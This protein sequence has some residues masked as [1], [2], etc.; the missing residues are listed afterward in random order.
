MRGTEPMSALIDAR[1]RSVF[2]SA[3]SSAIRMMSISTAAATYSFP[4]S[5]DD[6]RDRHEDLGPDLAL[7]KEVQ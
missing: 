5:S 2:I 3:I 6:G 7:P 4:R 1:A